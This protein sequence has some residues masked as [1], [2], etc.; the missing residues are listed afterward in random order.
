MFVHV[1][2]LETYYQV[3]GEGATVVLL[4]GWGTSGRSLE[5]VSAAL[6]DRFRVFRLD[7]PGFGWSHEPSSVWGSVDYAAHVQATLDALGVKR[8]AVL[9]HSFGGRV[10]VVLAATLPERVV[11][12]VLVASAGV[13]PR[14]TLRIYALLTTT[15]IMW[16]QHLR[17]RHL[18]P[19]RQ[20]SPSVTLH[21]VFPRLER[22]T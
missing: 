2:G 5:A 7:L 15:K 9:G 1:G 3:E 21:P 17:R 19:R 6:A 20:S 14:R 12:L 13:R 8:A 4:H 22:P 10:A 11:R 18:S 16:P